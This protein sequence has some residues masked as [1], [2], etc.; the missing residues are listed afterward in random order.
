[1]IDLRW[2]LAIIGFVVGRFRGAMIGFFLGA[3]LNELFQNKTREQGSFNSQRRNSYQNQQSA[4]D[5]ELNLLKLSA[6]VITADGSTSQKELDYVRMEFVRMFGKS[7]ANQI[8]NLFKKEKNRNN[9][10]QE[11]CAKIRQGMPAAVRSQ[12]LHYLF[13]IALADGTISNKEVHVIAQIAQQL[14][15]PEREFFAIKAMFMHQQQNKHSSSHMRPSNY[16]LKTA[17][18]I[19]EIDINATDS[20]V[21][22]AYRSLVK[23]YHPDKLQH[24]GEVHVKAAEEKFKTIQEAYEKIR[25]KR[26]MK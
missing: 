7:R 26:G 22:K 6:I 24:L 5:F 21:K 20:E 8:F 18:T 9:S 4:L 17:Y 11:I 14:R 16:S 25:I 15:I 12:L 10:L 19:L 2:V 3:L 1:M 23:K 13:K